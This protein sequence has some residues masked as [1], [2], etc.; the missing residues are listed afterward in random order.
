MYWAIALEDLRLPAL[1]HARRRSWASKHR[2]VHSLD[3]L[4]SEPHVL[5]AVSLGACRERFSAAEKAP[6]SL[7]VF[8]AGDRSIA[9]TDGTPT[10]PTHEAGE[11][12]KRLSH[13]PGPMVLLAVRTGDAADSSRF[14]CNALT[15]HHVQEVV[16]AVVAV[17]N[18]RLRLQ[19]S[20]AACTVGAKRPRSEDEAALTAASEL[21][22]AQSVRRKVVLTP[23]QL[24]DALTSLQAGAAD[25]AVPEEL[26]VE[27]AE[28]FF[29]GRTLKR[30]ARLSEYVG[31]NDKSQ[32][33]IQLL[34]ITSGNGG[35]AP[36]V[37]PAPAPA[38]PP[39]EPA[40]ASEAATG[41]SSVPESAVAAVVPAAP[42]H[43]AA[44]GGVSLN[45][46]FKAMRGEPT[47]EAAVAVAGG[48]EEGEDPA[49]LGEEQA[50]R[51]LRSQPV[52]AAMR[53]PRLQELLRCALPGPAR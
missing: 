42:A 26:S 17:H 39:S 16:E 10:T 24:L 52:Q 35:T 9:T 49:V 18:M 48:K 3:C 32:V 47:P 36:L 7:T 15:S 13:P 6:L 43:D 50:A 1:G 5:R 21:L 33:Q 53:D 51:L 20:V 27:G 4:S 19:A 30:D 46:Y 23:Q 34:R 38:M 25:R 22:S 8:L 37:P 44:A 14:L 12:S 31:K 11:T 40:A 45:S 28:L 2:E 29:A 41:S